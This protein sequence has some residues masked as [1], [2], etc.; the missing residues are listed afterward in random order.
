MMMMMM[1]MVVYGCVGCYT[2]QKNFSFFFCVLFLCFL[3]GFKF[4]KDRVYKVKRM[5]LG[6]I[7]NG[8]IVQNTQTT[9]F[10]DDVRASIAQ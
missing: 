7:P 2:T 10:F 5:V 3:F 1:M 6:S 8:G 4:S 9:T